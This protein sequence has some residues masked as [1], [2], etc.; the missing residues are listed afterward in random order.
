M[1][2]ITS[3]AN[4]KPFAINGNFFPSVAVLLRLVETTAAVLA[5][6]NVSQ[7]P[8]AGSENGRSHG[9]NP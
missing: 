4:K 1:I 7:N 5:N 8:Y 2:K 6:I 3:G 9:G